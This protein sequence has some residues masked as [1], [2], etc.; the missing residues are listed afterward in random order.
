MNFTTPWDT[1]FEQSPQGSE[2]VASGD[3]RIRELKQSI[4]ERVQDGWWE[5]LKAPVYLSPSSFYLTGDE[6]SRYVQ[7]RP[8]AINQ[9]STTVFTTVAESSYDSGADRT[10]VVVDDEILTSSMSK[11]FFAAYAFTLVKVEVPDPPVVRGTRTGG[12]LEALSNG[13]T[14]RIKSGEWEMGGV[15]YRWD[16]VLDFGIGPTGTNPDSDPIPSSEQFVYMYLD[17]DKIANPVE[18]GHFISKSVAPTYSPEK[19]GWY[20]GD[21]RC[22]GALWHDGTVLIPA[23]EQNGIMI[24]YDSTVRDIAVICDDAWHTVTVPKVPV[25]STMPWLN[26][27]VYKAAELGNAVVLRPAGADWPWHSGMYTTFT[28][29][30]FIGLFPT[31]ES[32]QI[33]YSGNDGTQIDI[34][35]RGFSTE[36]L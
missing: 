8:L 31:D 27:L 36:G 21:D 13:T 5:E 18:A 15:L 9:D 11:V 30:A 29:G 33:E 32:R 23:K 12:Q 24:Y 14:V 20:D 16:E 28:P 6:T 17:A 2:S 22:I 10:T 35:V 26:V 3:D 19:H 7:G 25:F 34:K 4:R 1:A